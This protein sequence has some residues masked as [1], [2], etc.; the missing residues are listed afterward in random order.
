MMAIG[1]KWMTRAAGMALALSA[2]AWAQASWQSAH[3]TDSSWVSGSCE[4]TSAAIRVMVHPAWLE[5]EEDL[6]IAPVGSV[7][8]GADA[9]T[10]EIL[11]AFNLPAGAAITGALLWDGDKVLQARLLDKAKADSAYQSAVDRNSLPP[12]RPRDPILLE[13]LSATSYQIHLYPAEISKSRHFRLRY[14]LPPVIGAEGLEMGL[15]TAVASLFPAYTSL[16]SVSFEGA[17]VSQAVLSLQDG[18]RATL[19]LPRTRLMHASDLSG[20]TTNY[21][22]WNYQPG[23]RLLPADAKRQVAVRTSIGSG[24]MQGQYLNLY[25][26]V[27]DE[28]LAGMGRRVEVAVYWKWHS[29]ALWMLDNQYGYADYGYIYQAQSQAAGLLDLFSQMGGMGNKIG[30]LHDDGRGDPKAFKVAS[31]GEA[32]YQSALD[33]LNHLQGNYVADFARSMKPDSQ[34]KP[35]DLKATVRASKDRFY[36][37]IKLVKSL[38][39]PATGVVRHL[40][41]VSTGPEN[42]TSDT[43]ANAFFDSAFADVPVSVGTFSGSA[44]S[45]A[46]FDAWTAHRD[47][48]ALGP[49]IST[50]YGPLPGFDALNLNVVVRNEGKSYDFPIRCEGGL[51]LSCG[52]LT[53][54]GKSDR[55]WQ[56]SLEWEAFDAAGKRIGSTKSLP[57]QIGGPEDTSIAVLWAGSESPF[58]ENR[59]EPPLGP[60]YGFVDRWASLIGVAKDSLK[61]ASTYADTGV[62]RVVP[63]QL[64]DV[65]PNY[66][67][68]DAPNTGIAA[69]SD[70]AR[71]ADPARWTLERTLAGLIIR[72][73]GLSSGLDVAV[74]LFDME[75]KRA[76][77]WSTR[78]E[79]GA[80][81]LTTPGL[82]S[83]LYLL[84]VR[85]A[86]MRMAKRI[87]L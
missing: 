35:G 60:V 16:I 2:G 37:N 29:P 41:L 76:G 87:V 33:Y 5:V 38:Y 27:T 52:T 36:Q 40:I 75:G 66:K 53:F 39:S 4:L 24:Q 7:P 50:G 10:L 68:G 3:S 84:K 32:E 13:M 11:G 77:S 22:G 59:Q 74:E 8:G 49:Q 15:Q 18:S 14:Q 20:Q 9:K 78:S 70:L 65:L 51:S 72:I 42:E 34:P 12:P 80:F 63:A 83:G 25:A 19:G 28:V 82:R 79:S 47:H 81:R 62:P 55:V 57:Q 67:P 31:R 71:L 86:G 1:V 26:G 17:G 64:V 30:L 54:H 69:R 56:D 21:Y 48:P 6:D 23:V 58:S 46:G 61:N 85:I 43:E 44:F 73:P 45:Q